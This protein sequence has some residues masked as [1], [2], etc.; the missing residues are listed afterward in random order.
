MHAFIH[1]EKYVSN[2]CCHLHLC[3]YAVRT[4][5][6][7]CC[8]YPLDVVNSRSSSF[9]ECQEK[10]G[11]GERRK[12]RTVRTLHTHTNLGS[13]KNMQM[14][15]MFNCLSDDVKASRPF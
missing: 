1:S 3:T 7:R 4:Y 9:N 5:D 14:K 2:T 10:M 11:E 15:D 8:L 6:M 13:K 12:V